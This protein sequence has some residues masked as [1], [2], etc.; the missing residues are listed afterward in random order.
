MADRS[1]AADGTA[2]AS[3]QQ[4]AELVDAAVAATPG[5]VRGYR[6]AHALAGGLASSPVLAHVTLVPARS[7]VVSIGVDELADSRDV[8]GAVAAAVR[9]ALPDDWGEA[10]V[11]V[12]VRRVED[13]EAAAP[14]APSTGAPTAA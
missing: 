10:R 8:A 5:V 7:V 2:G 3:P 4:V 12:Q 1:T 9:R 6:A 14:G 13:A 11:R